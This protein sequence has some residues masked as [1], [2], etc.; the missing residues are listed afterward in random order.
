MVKEQ[1]I[2]E[3][4]L[5]E[6]WKNQKFEKPITTAD[7]EA[8][9]VIYPGEENIDKSGPDFINGRI[10]IGNIT[11]VGDIEIDTS[12]SDWKAHGHNLNKR[13]NKVILHATLENDS[14][15][16]F[17]YTQNNR[18][19]PT[20]P[21]SLFLEK[22]L[23]ESLTEVIKEKNNKQTNKMSC[24]QL[25][26][27][28]NDESKIKFLYDL[29]ILRF[30]RKCERLLFRLKELV[31]IN[32]LE[33]KEP[34]IQYDI[35]KEVLEKK[36][37]VSDI[38]HN[39]LWEQLLYENIFEALGYS[40]NK[41][42][43]LKLSQN[44]DLKF[45][46]S[47]LKK[48]DILTL[49]AIYFYVGGLIPDVENIK[50]EK[51]SEYVRTLH[52]KWLNV[53]DKYDKKYF[54]ENEWHFFKLRPQN[55]PT[56][57]IAG[58]AKI[59]H[60]IIFG[61]LTMTLFKKIKEIHNFDVLIKSVRNLFIVKSDEFWTDHFVFDKKTNDKVN[62]LV[63]KNRAD[64]IFVNVILPFAYVYFNSFGKKD[65]AEKVLKIYTYSDLST[66]NSLVN[67][68]SSSL[69]LKEVN[70]KSVIYQGMIELFRTYC[71][72]GQCMNCKIG[73]VVFN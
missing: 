30:K 73:T 63:G 5:Y 55:F 59:A 33:V 54:H 36:L 27:L 52:T 71:S 58:G 14:H 66:E 13:F 2:S 70:K 72:K 62:Y 67:E 34:M 3:K 61:N 60:Q 15:Q 6:I 1:K 57:R 17:V 51:T 29:G 56:I 69:N 23:R 18:K 44:V 35:P 10:K 19:V 50:D 21:I 11:Y 22:S 45:L 9:Q 37:L 31:Y 16:F 28:A 41:N 64:E 53:K 20:V 4:F 32:S 43:M 42:I 7:G 46:K 49:E 40:Q 12:H 68:I 47:V 38:S 26:D 39:E 8:I 24:M 25:S 65:L 48:Y